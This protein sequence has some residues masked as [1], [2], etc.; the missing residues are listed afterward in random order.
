MTAN[1][2]IEELRKR[3]RITITE[4]RKGIQDYEVEIYCNALGI[5]ETTL[6]W[7]IKNYKPN[8][9]EEHLKA[10]IYPTKENRRN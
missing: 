8:K 6:F 10:K 9:K 4:L 5:T 3:F 2:I 7:A 1:K